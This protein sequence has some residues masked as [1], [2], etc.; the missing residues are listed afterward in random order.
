MVVCDLVLVLGSGMTTQYF[1]LFMMKLYD[2]SPVVLSL[3]GLANSLL[4]A[5]L[6]IL[7]GFIGQR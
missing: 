1:A 3:L 5:F 4:I 6:A 7:N 2:V